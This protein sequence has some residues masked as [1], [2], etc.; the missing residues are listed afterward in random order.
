[1]KLS[2]KG[3][4]KTTLLDYPEEVA[5]TLFLGGCNF[6]C[7]YCFNPPLVFNQDT[8]VSISQKEAIAFLKER[9]KFLDGVCITGGEPLLY[10]LELISF[11]REV[12]SIGYKIKLDT[13]GSFPEILEEIVSNKLVDYVAM[14]IKGPIEK[15]ADIIKCEI[16]LDKIK[17]SVEIIKKSKIDYEFR[18]TVFNGL[19]ENDFIKI[20]KWLCGSKKYCLQPIKPDVPLLDSSFPS[21]NMIPPHKKLKSI[22]EKIKNCFDIVEIRN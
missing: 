5:C 21:T 15:Y 22:V 6:R 11:F 19:D 10:G 13:N 4:Q 9:S 7:F 14:D 8:G 1:M 12:K 3:I 16:D 2:F 18:T 20:A 17:R